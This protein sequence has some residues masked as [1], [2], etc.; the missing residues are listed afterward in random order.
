MYEC[1]NIYGI[2]AALSCYNLAEGWYDGGVPQ[3]NISEGGTQCRVVR[4]LW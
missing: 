3:S 1:P 4:P 2:L